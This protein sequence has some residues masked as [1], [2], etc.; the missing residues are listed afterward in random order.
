MGGFISTPLAQLGLISAEDD[1]PDSSVQPATRSRVMQI[2]RETHGSKTRTRIRVVLRSRSS[3]SSDTTVS[4]ESSQSSESL[5]SDI[6]SESG[7]SN[8]SLSTMGSSSFVSSSSDSSFGLNIISSAS[9][10]SSSS[11]SSDELA[12]RSPPHKRPRRRW[13]FRSH[14]WKSSRPVGTDERADGGEAGASGGPGAPGTSDEL[15]SKLREMEEA[16]TCAIC[17]NRRRNMAFMCGHG[18]CSRCAAQIDI[19]HIC[20][21]PID[22]KIRLH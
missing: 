7:S 6:A 19:C 15:L 4:S 3:S 18:S 8:T 12:T 11:V 21:R 14:R 17:M 13:L 20:R 10:S 1:R 2:N 22:K 9:S 16:L 5:P